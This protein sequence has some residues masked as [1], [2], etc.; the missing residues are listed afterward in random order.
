MSQGQEASSTGR[1]RRRTT[2][3][4]VKVAD[5]VS[6][7]VI[8]VGGI[9]TI[10]AVL[11]IVVFLIWVVA[12]LFQGGSAKPLEGYAEP[13]QPAAAVQRV[14]LDGYLT[15]SWELGRDGKV[16]MRR[17]DDG[18]VVHEEPLFPEAQVRAISLPAGGGRLAFGLEDGR[19]VLGRIAFETTYFEPGDEA[20]PDGLRTLKTG[21]VATWGDGLVQ[22]TPAHQVRRQR[23]S[24]ELGEPLAL[25]GSQAVVG[26]DRSDT[27]QGPVFAAVTA[28]GR[29]HVRSVRLRKNLMTGKVTQRVRG[30]DVLVPRHG[31]AAHPSRVVLS[32]LA[33]N[34]YL[35]WDDG[36]V[37]RYNV[38]DPRR[39]EVVEKRA[40]L[41]ADGARVT[42]LAALAGKTTIL[43]GDDRSRVR[44]WFLTVSPTKET[45]D[46][47]NLVLGRTFEGDGSPIRAIATSSRTRLAAAGCESGRIV[48]EYVSSSKVVA[49][50]D[51][52]PPVESLVLAPRDD[53][54]LALGGA[55]RKVWSV[56]VGY[57]EATPK[58][59][60][61][62]VLYEGYAEPAYVWQ[63]TGGSDDFEPKLSLVPLIFGTLKA[64]LFSML[65][66]VPLA[67]LGAIYTSEFLRPSWRA[68]IKPAVEVMA[69]LPSVVLGFLAAY[70]FAPVVERIVPAILLLFL[71]IP[72]TFVL[73]AQLFQ[74]LPRKTTLRLERFRLLFL[75]FALPIGVLLAFL[76]APGAEALFFGGDFEAWLAGRG[77][78]AGGGW[79]FALLPVAIVF[80]LGL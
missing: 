56:E 5:R 25:G 79:A 54:L 73:G 24:I 55:G 46:R 52:P 70:L 78:P 65:F 33:D 57:P 45:P 35:V 75:L 11:L 44:A 9:G 17:L 10:A 16:R 66:A 19:V 71:T 50:M 42:A 69:S 3:P 13:G 74:L 61:G 7:A 48:L 26:I 49:V 59:I 8:T 67:L 77:G 14:S 60:F 32:G 36:Y 21:E 41:P 43:V 6:R 2:R 31:T 68:A 47:M 29:L 15:A 12:P 63:T 38:R 18:S 30:A 1:A 80:L 53:G 20:L 22:A 64:T 34:V 51:G 76:L 27:S 62:K 72:F 39:P 28:D 58:T 4:A 23:L 40:L 37:V